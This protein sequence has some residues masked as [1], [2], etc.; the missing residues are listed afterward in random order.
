MEADPLCGASYIGHGADEKVQ[1]GKVLPENA[2]DYLS[3]SPHGLKFTLFILRGM[4][5]TIMS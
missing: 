2:Y 1:V 4:L 5:Y 3:I